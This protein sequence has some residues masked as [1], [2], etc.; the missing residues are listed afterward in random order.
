M[1]SGGDEIGQ[2]HGQTKIARVLNSKSE[3]SFIKINNSFCDHSAASLREVAYLTGCYDYAG[4]HNYF[5]K[6]DTKLQKCEILPQM[7]FDVDRH[8]SC[9]VETKN[10]IYTFGGCPGGG[11]PNKITCFDMEQMEWSQVPQ[12]CRFQNFTSTYNKAAKVVIWIGI[13]E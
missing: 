12:H 10:K 8:A 5:E 1:I 13:Q 4:H 9:V 2:N 6:I 7:I 3:A 11:Q